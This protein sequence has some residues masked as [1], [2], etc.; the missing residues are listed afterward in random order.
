MDYEQRTKGTRSDVPTGRTVAQHVL[1]S[2]VEGC[3][4]T[5]AGDV[6]LHVEASCSEMVGMRV[7]N[8]AADRSHKLP[9]PFRLLVLIHDVSHT[10]VPLQLVEG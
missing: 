3:D 4:M 5:A 6:L 2:Q 8:I 7:G 9:G 10:K 1:L